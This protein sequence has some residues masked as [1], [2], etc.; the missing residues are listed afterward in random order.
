MFPMCFFS[1]L[2]AIKHSLALF[3]YFGKKYTIYNNVPGFFSDVD[4]AAVNLGHHIF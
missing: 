2:L 4:K 1:P 3:K